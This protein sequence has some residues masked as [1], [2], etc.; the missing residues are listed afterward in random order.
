MDAPIKLD[1]KGKPVFICCK[2]CKAKVDKDPDAILA[3][4][5]ELKKAPQVT[6]QRTED[7]EQRTEDRRQ[8]TGIV[9]PFGLWFP[10]SGVLLCQLAAFSS[11]CQTHGKFSR[12]LARSMLHLD[13]YNSKN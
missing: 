10:F 4:V 7:R 2:G 3:K 12:L 11:A 1:V 8:R 9:A 13:N 6:R 5:E